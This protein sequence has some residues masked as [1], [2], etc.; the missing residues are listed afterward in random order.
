MTELIKSISTWW[1]YNRSYFLKSSLIIHVHIFWGVIWHVQQ[2]VVKCLMISLP[3]FSYIHWLI[4][5]NYDD[6]ILNCNFLVLLTLDG[7]LSLFLTGM[8]RIS[9]L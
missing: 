6:T 7:K 1:N 5:F 8:K 2:N 4:R 3:R 9:M